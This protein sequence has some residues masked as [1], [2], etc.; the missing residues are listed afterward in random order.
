MHPATNGRAQRF[1]QGRGRVQLPHGGDEGQAG[2]AAHLG[3]GCV[4]RNRVE[5]AALGAE[6]CAGCEHGVE[7]G[8]GDGQVARVDQR[9]GRGGLESCVSPMFSPTFSRMHRIMRSAAG[10]SSC[11]ERSVFGAHATL[12]QRFVGQADP[13][14]VPVGESGVGASVGS[15]RCGEHRGEHYGNQHPCKVVPKR[16]NESMNAVLCV[17]ARMGSRRGEAA[18]TK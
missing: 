8:G 12:G 13:N 3:V 4:D 7:A 10:E 17:Q 5:P 16:T 18:N 11:R 15:D 14:R 9:R 6:L 2:D 1:G